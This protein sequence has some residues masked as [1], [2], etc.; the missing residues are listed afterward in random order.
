MTHAGL[1]S[2]LAG[3][4]LAID[5]SELDGL[6]T[7]YVCGGGKADRQQILA[8]LQLDNEDPS[9]DALLGEMHDVCVQHL[10]RLEMS[11]EPLLPAD[12][13]PLRE[14]VDALVDW[15]RGFLGGF[16]LAGATAEA[17]SDDGREVLRDLGTIAASRL[18]LEDQDEDDSDADES[19]LIEL[20]EFVRVGAMLLHT[21]MAMAGSP[22]AGGRPH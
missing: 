3:A 1:E 21:E 5:A 22:P 7:G 2:A 19:A 20:L 8:A 16:G 10:G 11:L 6:L 13:K 17:L 18:T 15:T 4:T 14:R 9:L 12:T